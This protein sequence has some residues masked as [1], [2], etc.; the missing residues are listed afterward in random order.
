MA[1]ASF[2]VFLARR[3]TAAL[4]RHDY[5]YGTA[6]LK[7]ITQG[8]PKAKKRGGRGRPICSIVARLFGR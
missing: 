1:D 3:G 4:L 7:G 8:V 5:R 2:D 6:Y